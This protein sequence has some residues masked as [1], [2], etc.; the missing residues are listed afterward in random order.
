MQDNQH[1]HAE[2]SLDEQL[3]ATLRRIDK[4]NCA[5]LYERC[6]AHNVN[7]RQLR[8]LSASHIA[9]LIPVS[10]L[11]IRVEFEHLLKEWISKCSVVE[12]VFRCRWARETWKGSVR[13]LN[14]T[15]TQNASTMTVYP[16]WECRGTNAEPPTIAPKSQATQNVKPN[17]NEARK[18]HEDGTFVDCIELTPT[19]STTPDSQ[20]Y[21]SI[22]L[23]TEPPTIAPRSHATKNAKQ[24]SDEAK[25]TPAVSTTHYSQHYSLGK[26]IPV[27]LAECQKS[28]KENG[29]LLL[30]ADRLQLTRAIINYLVSR[31]ISFNWRIAE[32]LAD[33]ITE[34][35]PTERKHV[36]YHN[37]SGGSLLTQFYY[38]GQRTAAKSHRKVM[39]GYEEKSSSST[40]CEAISQLLNMWKVYWPKRCE[41]IKRL[42]PGRVQ[43]L[44]K[45][46]AAWPNYRNAYGTEL[47]AYDFEQLY[48]HKNA[49]FKKRWHIFS[50]TI[51]EH[52]ERRL[53]ICETLSLSHHIKEHYT[54]DVS[55]ECFLLHLMHF[56]TTPSHLYNSTD[57]KNLRQQHVIESQHATMRLVGNE[58][59]SGSYE[60]HPCIF[61]VGRKISEI[62]QCI[63]AWRDWRFQLPL[64]DALLAVLQIYLIFKLKIPPACQNFWQFVRDSFCDIQWPDDISCAELDDVK[65]FIYVK[66]VSKRMR[67]SSAL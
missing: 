13:S 5:Y 26:I 4:A 16:S 15:K 37:Y 12:K 62:T 36:W 58:H 14:E 43:R 39:E 55:R 46:F 3:Y 29:N 20:Q 51:A 17:N 21:V 44:D 33:Q 63:M 19:E 40:N 50:T 41:L 27:C 22:P 32:Q 67:Q 47:L 38:E 31:K 59:T 7:A 64:G 34:H 45:L 2:S 30:E 35:F 61:M 49:L 8:Y 6:K 53:K 42:K 60:L 54:N 52:L 48:P 10:Q 23:S 56:I 9:V 18:S 57:F 24:N 11:G 66:T 1:G 25:L 65:E 28:Y